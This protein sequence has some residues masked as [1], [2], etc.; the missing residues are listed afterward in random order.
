MILHDKTKV[1]QRMENEALEIAKK[2]TKETVFLRR[3][4]LQ[5]ALENR[6]QAM[7]VYTRSFCITTRS[8]ADMPTF[9]Y[10]LQEVQKAYN[11]EEYMTIKDCGKS[12]FLK[13]K[14][15]ILEP[16]N[17]TPYEESVTGSGDIS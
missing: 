12:Y 9:G 16:L 4:K 6:I 14:L 7:L 17:Q 13:E 10:T 8:L 3:K 11:P 1:I 2:I 5:F 15:A